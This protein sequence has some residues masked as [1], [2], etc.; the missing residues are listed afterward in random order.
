M[1]T[2]D[3]LETR[4]LWNR[5]Q[6][7]AEEMYDTAERLA[8]SLSI[9]EG[10]DASTA[11][12]TPDGKAIGL[13]NQSVPVLSGAVARS[14]RE[15]L[16]GP[17][18]GED[19]RDGDVLVTNDPWLGGGHL[20]DVVVLS[21]IFHDG[22][23][24]GLAG[25]LG[26][27]DDVGGNIGGWSTEASDVTEEGLLIEPTKLY[28]DGERSDEVEEAIRSTVR[29]PNQMLGDLEALRSANAVGAARLRETVS[30]FGRETVE[31]V[32][33]EV[34][35]R[36][37]RA[38]RESL[39]DVP[40]GTYE[41]AVEFDVADLSPRIEVAVT[42]AGDDLIVDYTGT[43][44]T[45]DG[46]I[47][48]PFG[49]TRS[50]TQ[51]VV[52]CMLA[53]DLPNAEGFFRPIDVRAPEGCIL[54][55]ERPAPTMGRHLT[56]ARAE[57]ALIHALGEVLPEQALGE[58]AGIQLATFAGM[59]PDGGMYVSIAGTSGGM[60]AR[61]TKDGIGGVVFPYNGQ[62]TPVEVFEQYSPLRHA[63][64]TF[65][66]DSEGAGRQRSG[67]AVR[68][69]VH[70]PLDSPAQM[71]TTSGNAQRAPAGFDGGHEGRPAAIESLDDDRSI[72][73]NGE[74]SLQPG[75]TLRL[76]SATPG[77]YG[78]PQERDP[79]AVARDIR[80]GLLSPD[81]ARDVYGYT[82]AHSDEDS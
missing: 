48:C 69:E 5:L 22:E 1:T 12:M 64:A 20:S 40:D 16:A 68:V 72:P 53:P 26:H 9:R 43:S 70:N 79:A 29:L 7:A 39:V 35:D 4:V 78:D 33:E 77:G 81:R 76:T 67:F 17:F 55:C 66:P 36:S 27:T 41:T 24:V 71:T 80:R 10:A 8:F 63:G 50:V 59:D 46:G 32:A 49:N 44:G 6:A 21:P 14:A 11:L 19:L 15:V 38:L 60:P 2:S 52:K 82:G 65:V 51:Y 62:S 42:V 13:S 31:R 18:A 74:D 47:N 73:P 34:L 25:S 28:V 57:D 58:M 61:A 37:E 3:T 45:V 56:Y 54:A 30:E 23:L 75:E